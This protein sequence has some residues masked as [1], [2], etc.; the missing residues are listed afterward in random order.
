MNTKYCI[1]D[2]IVYFNWYFNEPLDNYTNIM[3]N[4]TKITFSNYTIYDISIRTKMNTMI[5]IAKNIYL[6]NLINH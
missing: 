1:Q 6:V 2:D 3:K 4:C 5:N